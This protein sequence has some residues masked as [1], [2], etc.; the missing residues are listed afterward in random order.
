MTL[1][2]K[3][4]ASL[5]LTAA[6][7]VGAAPPA[8]ADE[9]GPHWEVTSDCDWVQPFG[10]NAGW[11]SFAIPVC[12][13]S[14]GMSTLMDGLKIYGFHTEFRSLPGVQPEIRNWRIDYLFYDFNGK[15]IYTM[16]G[17]RITKTELQ[18]RSESYVNGED[19]VSQLLT[20][21]AGLDW[22]GVEKVCSRLVVGAGPIDN[23]WEGLRANGGKWTGL[24]AC[25]S[26][27][28]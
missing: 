12:Q 23:K 28:V 1:R 20:L 21:T 14:L 7:V 5:G 15:R 6:L 10:A 9:G 8:N 16:Y 17:K 2:R 19:G 22:T 4:L 13:R 18:G 24:E 25:E 11:V 26:L 27:V 3:L